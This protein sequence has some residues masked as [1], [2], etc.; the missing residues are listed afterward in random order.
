MNRRGFL[1]GLIG[2]G[3]A[4]AVGGVSVAK[5]AVKALAEI[6]PAVAKPVSRTFPAIIDPKAAKRWSKMLMV[7]VQRPSYFSRKF[8]DDGSAIER[9]TDLSKSESDTFTYST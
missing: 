4:I 2:G 5:A 9:V 6:K 3:A 7:D 1:R 8:L